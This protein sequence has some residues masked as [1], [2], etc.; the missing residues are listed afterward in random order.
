MYLGVAQLFGK[1]LK[2]VSQPEMC[3][4]TDKNKIYKNIAQPNQSK[5]EYANVPIFNTMI[6]VAQYYG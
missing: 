2:V 4:N 6:L 3:I 5:R 1:Y